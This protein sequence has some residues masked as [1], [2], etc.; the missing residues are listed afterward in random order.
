V[1]TIT[2]TGTSV[3][4]NAPAALGSHTVTAT[5]AADATK[6][7]TVAIT[8]QTPVITVT[9]NP[10]GSATVNAA[11]SLA[12]TA[13]VTGS[14]STGVTW[15]VDGIAGGNTTVGTLTGT[16]SSVTYTAPAASGT[17]VV[18]AQSAQDTSKS[19][20]TT[21]TVQGSS[22]VSVSL[23][24][25][26]PANIIVSGSTLFTAK[27]TGAS[28]TTV[29]WTVDGVANGNAS[30]GAISSTV[31]GNTVMFTA[32]AATGTHT[33]TATSNADPSKSASLTYSVGSTY[34]PL[35]TIA[36]GANVKDAPYNAKGDGVTDDTAAI[37]A[38]VNAV[39]GTGKAVFIPAGTYM[40]NAQAN[41]GSGIR[42]GSNMTLLMDPAATLQAKYT[43]TMN[44]EV[45][46]VGGVHDV[47]IYGGI[48]KGNNGN[49]SIVT[50]TEEEDGN[51]IEIVTSTNVVVENVNTSNCFCDGV[52]IAKTA[53]NV[54]VCGVDS[55]KNIRNGMSIVNASRIVILN[56]N[57]HNNIG[58]VEV[59]GAG[60]INGNGM[61][62]EANANE[63]IST[64]LVHNCNFLNN[65]FAGLTW[66]IG[67]GTAPGS[68][69]DGIFVDSNTSQNNWAGFDGE[70]CPYSSV[71]NNTATNN[72]AYGIYIHDGATNSYVAYNTVSGTGSVEECAGI[73]LYQD[74]GTIVTHNSSTGNAKYGITAC[75]D[76][77]PTITNNIVTNN[78]V[79]GVRIYNS[80]G[81]VSTG[82]TQ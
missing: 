23:Q 16:G 43:A 45:I 17:H 15:T 20:S 3:T 49:N 80:T 75:Y 53:N 13:T 72:G 22:N 63:H 76:T 29:T 61:D 21:V 50:P 19:A 2:G 35:S 74:S 46:Y 64:V 36:I 44:Y 60:M 52:Y 27:V 37:N 59:P 4:Y 5:S 56:S 26:G 14:S 18:Q 66:G 8:L 31:P 32:P 25:V 73:M 40:I 62:I 71:T 57:F 7:A 51:A 24:G 78:P 30:V 69:T 79:M 82:N 70:N 42:L 67:F 12:F 38:A 77:N 54:V 58:S 9:L 39:A 68:T 41:S 55:S 48:I 6:G 28:D 65:Y 10:S 81:S 33:V 1:G 11:A 34:I 47:N